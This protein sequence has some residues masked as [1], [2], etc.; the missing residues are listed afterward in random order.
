MST[1]SSS[2]RNMSALEALAPS[3]ALIARATSPVRTSDHLS[4]A[5]SDASSDFDIDPDD[6]LDFLDSESEPEEEATA[7]PEPKSA[8][9]R[10]G[11]TALA[12]ASELASDEELRGLIEK[13]LSFHGLEPERMK[14]KKVRKAINTVVAASNRRQSLRRGSSAK[15][16]L[17]ERSGRRGSLLKGPGPVTPDA[18]RMGAIEALHPGMRIGSHVCFLLG[19][20]KTEQQAN[21]VIRGIIEGVGPSRDLLLV[22]SLSD[23][24]GKVHTVSASELYLTAAAASDGDGDGSGGGEARAAASADEAP[25]DLSALY[26]S[27]G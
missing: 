8:P 10:R 1:Y 21:A 18:L 2:L 25:P 17:S 26:R 22:R 14:S 27:I 7:P 3:Y 19:T 24:D 16:L 13:K 5:D 4:D 6:F 23:D 20:T 15:T 12:Q 11:S 9:G